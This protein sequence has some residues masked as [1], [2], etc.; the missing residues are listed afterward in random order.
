M[1]YALEWAGGRLSV[2]FNGEPCGAPAKRER[3]MKCIT[4][5]GNTIVPSTRPRTVRL[6]D[7]RRP[8]GGSA[9]RPSNASE[10]QYVADDP[11]AVLGLVKLIEARTWD[12]RPT[13]AEIYSAMQR[14]N[15]G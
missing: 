7:Q 2:G 3:L 12:W 15:L 5:M 11:V 4:P 10:E 6:Y 14:Y 9:G 13:D 8:V 1:D